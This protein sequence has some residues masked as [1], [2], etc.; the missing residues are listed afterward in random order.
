MAKAFHG[1]L[2]DTLDALIILEGCRQGLLPKINR[3]LLAAERGEFTEQPSVLPPQSTTASSS[4]QVIDVGDKASARGDDISNPSLITPGSVFVFDETES[5]I[6]RWTDGRIWS[7]SRICGNYLIYRELFRKLSSEKCMNPA[8]KAKMKDG[9]G[10]KDRVLQAR[11]ER[12]NLEV[13]G[14]MKGTFV[15]K[16][17]GLIKKTICVRGVNILTAAQLHEHS[18]RVGQGRS[19][20][21]VH[22]TRSPPF[23]LAGTQHLVCYEKPGAMDGL[24]RPRDYLELRNLALSRT[25]IIKQKFRNKMAILQLQEGEQPLD[26]YDE[27][28]SN[29]RVVEARP[30]Q[31]SATER[32]PRERKHQRG[33]VGGSS[34]CTRSRTKSRRSTC[35]GEKEKPDKHPQQQEKDLSSYKHGSDSYSKWNRESYPLPRSFGT[36]VTVPNHPYSTRGQDRRQRQALKQQHGMQEILERE[37]QYVHGQIHFDDTSED[38]AVERGR[39]QSNAAAT[40]APTETRRAR[41]RSRDSLTSESSTAEKDDVGKSGTYALMEP[42]INSCQGMEEEEASSSDYDLAVHGYKTKEGQWQLYRGQAQY[43]EDKEVG[44]RRTYS[45]EELLQNQGSLDRQPYRAQN[46]LHSENANGDPVHWDQPDRL[47]EQ[48]GVAWMLKR[49]PEGRMGSPMSNSGQAMERSQESWDAEDDF[50]HQKQERVQ[51]RDQGLDEDKYMQDSAKRIFQSYELST[52]E[53]NEASTKSTSPTEYQTS[54]TSSPCESLSSRASL[55]SSRSLSPTISSRD[56]SAYSHGMSDLAVGINAVGP[57]QQE[58]SDQFAEW[59]TDPSHL[60]ISSSMSADMTMDLGHILTSD[61]S[62]VC[63]MQQTRASSQLCVPGSDGAMAIHEYKSDILA[64]QSHHQSQAYARSVSPIALESVP[65]SILHSSPYRAQSFSAIPDQVA[66]NA[67]APCLATAARSSPPRFTVSHQIPTENTSLFLGTSS[68]LEGSIFE[69]MT[70]DELEASSVIDHH[71][72][73]IPGHVNVLPDYSE[74][75]S[76]PPHARIPSPTLVA[77]NSIAQETIDAYKGRHLEGWPYVLPHG[78][79]SALLTHPGDTTKSLQQLFRK[80]RQHTSLDCHVAPDDRGMERPGVG[81]GKLRDSIS[82]LT[83]TS[84]LGSDIIPDKALFPGIYSSACFLEVPIVRHQSTS[85]NLHPVDMEP[86]PHDPSQ[87]PSAM[88]RQYKMPSDYLFESYEEQSGTI[89]LPPKPNSV[90]VPIYPFP[91]ACVNSGPFTSTADFGDRIRFSGVAPRSF[92]VSQ[93]ET[94]SNYAS[95]PL[96]F[97]PPETNL[98]RPSH[99]ES[100]AGSHVVVEALTSSNV[101]EETRGPFEQQTQNSFR[102]IA[103]HMDQ[104]VML[105]PEMLSEI[106]LD[107]DYTIAP[108]AVDTEASDEITDDDNN[109]NDNDKDND[110]DDDYEAID[111]SP[112]IG[113]GHDEYMLHAQRSDISALSDPPQVDYPSYRFSLGNTHSYTRHDGHSV[114]M[115]Q[116]RLQSSDDLPSAMLGRS[117][118][119]ENASQGDNSSQEVLNYLSERRAPHAVLYGQSSSDTHPYSDP[120]D[121]HHSVFPGEARWSSDTA[122]SHVELEDDLQDELKEEQEKDMVESEVDTEVKMDEGD[123]VLKAERALHN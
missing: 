47:E 1:R 29:R 120:S 89:Q 114:H 101:K 74:G 109:S 19:I 91:Q 44:D 48:S 95:Q 38:G 30:T 26:P 64:P 57:G 79:T 121:N 87:Q 86:R 33:N 104:V 63:P 83:T 80:Q 37:D 12:D 5:G 55:S 62:V 7:P 46:S 78:L 65:K 67:L 8:E 108:A 103:T 116:T 9:S 6:C 76:D 52:M 72:T 18:A 36:T 84:V 70:L 32:K 14:C 56:R 81:E 3:R 31:R 11:V 102:A 88:K 115:G 25:F 117:L 97:S 98:K 24:H 92:S 99:L 27:Y 15:L 122:Y 82:T 28:I 17:D 59:R 118:Q 77:P 94:P 20:T 107:T 43:Q 13:L 34:M 68:K 71:C 54:C 111:S 42:L 119:H 93:L 2:E 23:S 96:Y 106:H 113:L 85:A 40:K 90:T 66:D 58:C 49:K 73:P 21:R 39:T 35:D 41:K 22:D 110:D 16:K 69:D 105:S 75:F 45:H 100:Q 112:S 50:Y 10:L 4:M 53:E 61:R 51:L 60:G 123:E